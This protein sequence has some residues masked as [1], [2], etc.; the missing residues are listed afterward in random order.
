MLKPYKAMLWGLMSTSQ[1]FSCL[2][3]QA[4]NSHFLL[5]GILVSAAYSSLNQLL[6]ILL[7]VE[8]SDNQTSKNSTS[9]GSWRWPKGFS[10]EL[11]KRNF[12]IW[13]LWHL[14]DMPKCLFCFLPGSWPY[15]RDKFPW[16]VFCWMR[17]QWSKNIFKFTS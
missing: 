15:F 1:I 3:C 10:R 5:M 9:K 4:V 14:F 13:T 17:C 2:F 16:T 8:K 11:E 6:L 7:W 12:S